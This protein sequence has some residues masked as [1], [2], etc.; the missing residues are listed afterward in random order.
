MAL[1]EFNQFELSP[2][3][4]GYGIRPS[5]FWLA[6][7]DTVRIQT[8]SINDAHLLLKGMATL[9]YPVGGTYLFFG[10][11]LDFTDY[12]QLLD[13]KKKIGYLTT[14]SALISNRSIRENLC[15][16]KVYFDN[17]LS[18]TLDEETLDLCR[19]FGLN[20][21]LNDRP[22]NLGV[23]DIRRAMLIRELTK[24]PRLMLV[25]YP[26]GFSGQRYLDRM[27]EL[28]KDAVKGGMTLVYLSFDQDFVDAFP[29]KCIDI[30]EGR[31]TLVNG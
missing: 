31:V 20:D 11:R 1:I 9:S 2:E 15:M 8:D 29:G 14:G 25:E 7:G 19:Y 18:N 24:K 26:K 16:G 17:D 12:R 13:T 3:K 28:I 27:V 21:V 23:S 22:V 4:K 30:R 5:T 10:H 6:G